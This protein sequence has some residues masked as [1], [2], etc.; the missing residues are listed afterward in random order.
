[1]AAYVI[2][3]LLFSIL[4][5]LAGIGICQVMPGFHRKVSEFLTPQITHEEKRNGPRRG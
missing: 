3:A 2:H 4:G 5:L 1:M